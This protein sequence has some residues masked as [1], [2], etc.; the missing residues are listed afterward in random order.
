MKI[1]SY[2]RSTIQ[3]GET[4]LFQG[5]I[6]PAYMLAPVG[7]TVFI[8]AAIC[9]AIPALQL[10]TVSPWVWAMLLMPAFYFCQHL[11]TYLTAESALTTHRV[12]SKTG[13]IQ[14][15]I[16]EIGLSKIE[17]SSIDQGIVGRLFGFGDLVIRGSGGHAATGTALAEVM[18]FRAAIQNA[19]NLQ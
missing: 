17:S 16:S 14:R 11:I 12:L 8:T 1:P 4:I 3:P 19:T 2:L 18:A 5:K 7:W 15:N 9:K 13:L 6:H 10:A